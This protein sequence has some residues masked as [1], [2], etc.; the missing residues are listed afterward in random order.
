MMFMLPS[1]LRLSL[2]LVVGA[3]AVCSKA[4]VVLLQA[5]LHPNFMVNL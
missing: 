1:K 4:L 2:S 5:E 3:H